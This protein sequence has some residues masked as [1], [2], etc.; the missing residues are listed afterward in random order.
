MKPIRKSLLLAG[1]LLVA[2]AV[3]GVAQ[4]RPARSAATASDPAR[5]IT[6]TGNGA[7]TAVPDRASFDFGVTTKAATAKDALAKNSAAAAAVIAALKAAGVASADLQ[8]TGVTLSPQTNSDGTAIIGYEADDSVSAKTALASAGA[9]VDAAVAAGADSV[10]GPSL[11]VADQSALYAQALT[12]AV[13]DAKG[14]AKTLAAA[15]G[16]TLGA[17]QSISED[18]SSPTPIPFG[19]KAADSTTPIEP[20]SQETDAS[21]TVVYAVS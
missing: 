3:A 13:A 19:A 5:T 12:Q 16:L 20:G 11:T 18:S 2:A 7:V 4:P 17:V 9:L 15:A 8:T 21:V 14:K 10:S 6:V 1:V